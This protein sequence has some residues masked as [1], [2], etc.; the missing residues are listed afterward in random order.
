MVE[1]EAKSIL[2]SFA[3]KAG[4]KRGCAAVDAWHITE[5]G[6]V[7]PMHELYVIGFPFNHPL[8]PIS[9]QDHTLKV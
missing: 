3:V 6:I 7:Y 9:R 4:F 8:T 1:L 2:D 5:D